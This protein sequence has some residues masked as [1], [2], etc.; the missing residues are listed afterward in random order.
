MT[1]EKET[2][3]TAFFSR[4]IKAKREKEGIPV[5]EEMR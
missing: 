4:E 3:G 5:G 1:R 2:F